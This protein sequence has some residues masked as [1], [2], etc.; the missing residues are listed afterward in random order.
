MRHARIQFELSTEVGA[1]ECVSV[2][3]SEPDRNEVSSFSLRAGL[4]Y[5]FFMLENIK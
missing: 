4:S 5:M 3:I 1:Y 2:F